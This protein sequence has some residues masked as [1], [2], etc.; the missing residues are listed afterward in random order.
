MVNPPEEA[1]AQQQAETA[2]RAGVGA[3][4]DECLEEQAQEEGAHDIDPDG[5]GGDSGDERRHIREE[6]ARTRSRGTAQEDQGECSG[7]QVERRA[8]GHRKGRESATDAQSAIAV[9]RGGDLLGARPGEVA[10]MTGVR[11]EGVEPALGDHAVDRCDRIRERRVRIERVGQALERVRDRLRLR[12]VDQLEDCCQVDVV[13]TVL[14]RG[15]ASGAGELPLVGGTEAA[16]LR[17]AGRGGE[18]R[19]RVRLGRR[20]W[21]GLQ[22]W[23]GL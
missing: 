23:L 8:A 16:G 1:G 3:P 5:H 14:D 7:A 20:V 9:D 19:L 15:A 12:G 2:G 4:A 18:V 11:R 21:L 6:H 13:A 17:H 22:V 10:G